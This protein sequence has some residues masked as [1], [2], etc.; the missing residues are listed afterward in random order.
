MRF[1]SMLH[2]FNNNKKKCIVKIIIIQR[3][4]ANTNYNEKV[5][6]K[7]HQIVISNDNI[8]KNSHMPSAFSLLFRLILL[9]VFCF[10]RKNLWILL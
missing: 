1:K 2:P 7:P 10:D 9:Y 3:S 6:K 8:K 5:T 4:N